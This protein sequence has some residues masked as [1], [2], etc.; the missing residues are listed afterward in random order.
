MSVYMI[1][2]ASNL[3]VSDQGLLLSNMYTR[4]HTQVEG[5]VDEMR[6]NGSYEE[7]ERPSL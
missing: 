7:D 3:Y 1:M 4:M 2:V 5:S 6:S